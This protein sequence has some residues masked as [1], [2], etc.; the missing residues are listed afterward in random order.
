MNVY[1]LTKN[2]IG[3]K[4]QIFTSDI[5]K[6]APAKREHHQVHPRVLDEGHLI[7]D[8]KIAK[9]F[10]RK[11]NCVLETLCGF[12]YSRHNLCNDSYALI[13]QC[14]QQQTGFPVISNTG[15]HPNILALLKTKSSFA[16]IFLVTVRLFHNTLNHFSHNRYTWHCIAYCRSQV[17]GWAFYEAFQWIPKATTL[18]TLTEESHYL[19]ETWTTWR[20]TAAVSH[21]A[22]WD[23]WAEDEE[24]LTASC[25][26]QSKQSPVQCFPGYWW[27]VGWVAPHGSLFCRTRGSRPD[28]HWRWTSGTGTSGTG[29]NPR[30][31]KPQ[32]ASASCLWHKYN[33]IECESCQYYIKEL[34]CFSFLFEVNSQHDR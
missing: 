8:V 21:T 3:C 11:Y 15:N 1:L 16:L 32:N 25:H 9:A 7:S 28:C 17:Y 6:G 26:N 20:S 34:Q 29:P 14:T 33:I 12:F 30:L 22:G 24:R 4:V 18:V 31:S 23:W 19:A 27:S 5:L 2:H 13:Y 10:E